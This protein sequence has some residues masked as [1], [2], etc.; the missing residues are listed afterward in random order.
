MEI[1]DE[2]LWTAV[3]SAKTGWIA[4]AF[5]QDD[6]VCG[7][8]PDL[9]GGCRDCIVAQCEGS[10]AWTVLFNVTSFEMKAMHDLCVAEETD[11]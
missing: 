6:P 8:G 3:I 10:D 5:G 1:M 9:C 4:D 11:Q 2:K 7:G